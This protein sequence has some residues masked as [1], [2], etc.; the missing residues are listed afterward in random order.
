MKGN[1]PDLWVNDVEALRQKLGQR[2]HSVAPSPPPC[3]SRCRPPSAP[4]PY[5][6]PPPGS[7]VCLHCCRTREGSTVLLEAFDTVRA[8]EC[9]T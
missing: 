7:L 1:Q 6:P 5:C 9:L 3:G 8:G 4:S 2:W